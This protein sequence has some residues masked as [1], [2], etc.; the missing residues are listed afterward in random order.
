MIL[1][2]TIALLI[3]A[4]S[5]SAYANPGACSGSCQVHDPALIQRSSDGT[6]FRFSTG[7]KIQIATAPAIQGPWTVK[8]S[9]LP[10]GSEINLAGNQDLWAPDVHKIGSTYY[11]YYAVS[12]FGSQTSG[13][14]VATSNTMDV[15]SWTDHG[16]I[17]VT[18]D[19]SKPYNAIDP[20]LVTLA[21]GT[22]QLNFGSFWND[23]YQ[24]QMSSATDKGSN[25]ASQIAY[26]PSG[27]HSVEGSYMYYR[28]GYYYLF[29]SAGQCCGLNTNKPAAGKEYMIKVCRSTSSTSGFVS[30][31]CVARAIPVDECKAS[32]EPAGRPEWEIM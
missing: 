4:A 23:L 17:G 5:V 9:A 1:R 2:P 6:Y 30:V 20:N 14:G 8:G 12:T 29:W 28:S 11:L 7:N 25:A 26:D 27:S 3:A 21:S 16:S 31:T 22:Y 13:I 19:S 10:S 15:G 24:V 32:N 18:S